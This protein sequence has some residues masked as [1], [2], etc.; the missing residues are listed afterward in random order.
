MKQQIEQSPNLNI[1]WAGLIVEELIRNSIDH[2]IV[3]PGFRSAPLA[4]AISQHPRAQVQFVVDERAAAFV[5]LGYAR[6][7]GKPAVLVCTS[8]SAPTHYFPAVVEASQSHLPMILLTADRPPELLDCGASQAIQQNELYGSYVNWYKGFPWPSAEIPPQWI[9]KT[10]DQALQAAYLNSHRLPGPVHLNLP[11]REP[12]APQSRPYPAD[13]LKP[14]SKWLQSDQV[15]FRYAPTQL[16]TDLSALEAFL[17]QAG[18]QGLLVIGQLT[19]AD[20]AAVLSLANSLQWPVMADILSGLKLNAEL[21]HQLSGYDQLFLLPEFEAALQHRAVLHIGGN[22]V[23]G[24]LLKWLE[25][26]PESDYAQIRSSDQSQDPFHHDGLCVSGSIA[27]ICSELEQSL[28]LKVR[29]TISKAEHYSQLTQELF[30]TVFQSSDVLSEPL[31][32]HLI[33]AL[34]PPEQFILLGNSM[35]VREMDAYACPRSG[36]PEVWGIRPT[37]GIEGHVATAVGL[38]L[39]R[40]QPVTLVCGDLTLFHDLNSLYLAAQSEFPVTI[41]VINNQGGGIFQ[42]LP[43]G[44]TPELLDPWFST[45]QSID[46]AKAADLFA[47]NYYQPTNLETLTTALKQ[48]WHSNRSSL[49][50]IQIAQADTLQCH[51]ALQAQMRQQI[52][53]FS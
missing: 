33:A 35:S 10:I 52:E 28:V 13:Y 19:S 5:A 44:Q 11:F 12:L 45:P 50:E 37:S 18:S 51:R 49:I 22:V 24:R 8:G 25:K 17:H 48:A 27:S 21:Q 4:I 34:A 39:G 1:L 2:F 53:S 32:G 26:L 3:S 29:P 23:S 30:Q 20:Q 40:K 31:V 15:W 6:S 38:A 9:L 7:A 41:I 43:L 46:F 47:L 42:F 14:V 16:Q 36:P